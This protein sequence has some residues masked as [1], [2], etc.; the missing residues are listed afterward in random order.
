[1]LG[2]QAARLT[3]KN[4]F[5]AIQR[6]THGGPVVHAFRLIREFGLYLSETVR[7]PRCHVDHTGTLILDLK[8]TQIA[9]TKKGELRGPD[10]GDGDD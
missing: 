8:D 2:L 10:N 3:T 4:A 9:C 7:F 5:P 6:G 1:V